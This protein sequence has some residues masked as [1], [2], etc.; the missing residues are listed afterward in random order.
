M[1]ARRYFQGLIAA[2]L[3]AVFRHGGLQR[4]ALGDAFLIAEVHPLAILDPEAPPRTLSERE[5]VLRLVAALL[6]QLFLARQLFFLFALLDL[7]LAE[8]RFLRRQV[9]RRPRLA[10]RR[11]RRLDRG[12]LDARGRLVAVLHV[13]LLVHPFIDLRARHRG[14]EREDQDEKARSHSFIGFQ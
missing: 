7:P 6:A 13:A 5:L 12:R 8:L 11:G 10:L 4:F 1:S 9:L 14:G 2:I 3:P